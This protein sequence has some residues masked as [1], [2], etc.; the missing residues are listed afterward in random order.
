MRACRSRGSF[1]QYS[2]YSSAARLNFPLANASAALFLRSCSSISEPP[3]S[4]EAFPLRLSRRGDR[5]PRPEQSGPAAGRRRS[6]HRGTSEAPALRFSRQTC[7]A[8]G[9]PARSRCRRT[10][11]TAPAAPPQ[12]PRA[13]PPRAPREPPTSLSRALSTGLARADRDA[14]RPQRRLSHPALPAPS[15]PPPVPPDAHFEVSTAAGRESRRALAP[16]RRREASWAVR[17]TPTEKPTPRQRADLASRFA[18]LAVY[19][20]GRFDELP[21]VK[22]SRRWLGPFLRR[23]CSPSDRCRRGGRNSSSLSSISAPAA[24]ALSARTS[25]GRSAR[26]SPGFIPS[27]PTPA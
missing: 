9:P 3:T 15:P 1:W 7:R 14:Q 5:R 2:S 17:R 27:T 8:A 25:D 12:P 26:S 22:S 23:R 20:S 4:S 6:V 10:T 19:L 21:G 13:S 18:P 24:A 16:R 11:R